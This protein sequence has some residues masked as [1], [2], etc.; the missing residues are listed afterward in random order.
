MR[1]FLRV[2]GI[3]AIGL[4]GLAAIGAGKVTDAQAEPI[5]NFFELR[6]NRPAA[7]ASPL[8]LLY[9][10]GNKKLGLNT[11]LVYTPLHS[12]RFG[13][14]LKSGPG[15]LGNGATP[16]FGDAA[17]TDASQGG[18]PMNIETIAFGAQQKLNDQW[19]LLANLAWIN[20]ESE[21][22]PSL[23]PAPDF[24]VPM[25]WDETARY[26]LGVIFIPADRWSFHAK[27]SLDRPGPHTAIDDGG[28][29]M[30]QSRLWMATAVNY[31]IRGD[32]SFVLEYTRLAAKEGDPFSHEAPGDASG[33]GGGAAEWC[34]NFDAISA[35]L[36]IAF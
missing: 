27:V 2:I 22:D 9:G 23:G 25:I 17:Q 35:L 29:G 13:L 3:L 36:T 1:I 24:V 12:T 8:G 33:A 26:M 10:T 19:I 30:D 5:E 28:V 11:R 16:F 7:M 31:H 21:T 34:S 32:L 14:S 6:L 18:L 20:L 15:P 4:S